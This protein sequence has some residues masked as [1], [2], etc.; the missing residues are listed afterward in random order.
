VVRQ[1]FAKPSNAGSNP[2]LTSNLIQSVH[3]WVDVRVNVNARYRKVN[4]DLAVDT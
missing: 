4:F 2:V 1:R 3:S